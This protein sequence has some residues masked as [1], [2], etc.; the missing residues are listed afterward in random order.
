MLD[1]NCP[2]TTSSSAAQSDLCGPFV[3]ETPNSATNTPGIPGNSVAKIEL[4]AN[5]PAPSQPPHKLVSALAHLS[6]EPIRALLAATVAAELNGG[7]RRR[8][9]PEALDAAARQQIC[10]LLK[11]GYSRSLAA[12]ELG[13]SASTITR[14]M[15]R[16]AEFRHQVLEAE[17]L[18]DRTPL[19]TILQAAQTSWKAAAWLIK[20]HKPHLSTERR[21]LRETTRRN[22]LAME[23]VRESIEEDPPKKDPD[24]VAFGGVSLSRKGNKTIM[25]RSSKNR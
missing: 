8:G 12:A 15:Q 19:L 14:T 4:I 3:A 22:K 1:P 13:V 25:R 10:L 23:C 5:E 2:A 24:D 11:F 6:S 20:N 17:K 7:A 16:D 18:Y 21:T 9:R